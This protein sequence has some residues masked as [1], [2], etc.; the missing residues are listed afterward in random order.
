MLEVRRIVNLL[1]E[2]NTYVLYSDEWNDVWL[3]NIGDFDKVL[4]VIGEKTIRGVFIT[5]GHADHI[6]GFNK[7][8]KG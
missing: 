8:L 5:H 6:Y 4:S 7:V 1:Y 3:V 2:S